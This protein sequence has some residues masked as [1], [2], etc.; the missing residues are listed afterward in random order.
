MLPFLLTAADHN[1]TKAAEADCD[2]AYPDVCIPS[3]PPDLDCGDITHRNFTVTGDDPHGF[4][5]D[6]DGMGC[7]AR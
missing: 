6:S 2:P 4:D 3:P 7:E 1:L 5:G